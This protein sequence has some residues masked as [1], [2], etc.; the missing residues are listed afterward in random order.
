MGAAVAFVAAARTALDRDVHPESRQ[1]PGGTG[2]QSMSR[3][4]RSWFLALLVVALCAEVPLVEAATGTRMEP[5]A[6]AT[7]VGT[8]PVNINT[9]TVKE[10]MTLNGIG[11]KVAE[12]IVEYRDAHGPF[13]KP[14]E[15]RR[16]DGV[17][18]GLWEKNRDRIVIK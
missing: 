14:E 9:A 7:I 11:R 16:V 1:V 18:A 13:K 10:L 15:I 4:S 17:G 12:K 3:R 2:R 6:V 8:G 5:F